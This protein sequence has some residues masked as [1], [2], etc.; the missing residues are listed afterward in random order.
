MSSAFID[1]FADVM[2][3][4][5]TITPGVEDY[6]G[7]F[8]ASGEVINAPCYIEGEARLVRDR[9][10]IEVASTVQIFV[11]A[12]GLLPDTHRFTL[13]ARFSPRTDLQAIVVDKVADETGPAYEV[14]MLP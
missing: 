12:Y 3:D 13:P 9:A 1:F 7:A 4:T 5:V 8:V 2:T 6:T 11:A 10:G 14:V